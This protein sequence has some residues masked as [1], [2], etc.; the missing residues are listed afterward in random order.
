LGGTA[1]L[2]MRSLGGA[3]GLP[4]VARDAALVATLA[5]GN[6]TVQ[7]KGVNTPQVSLGGSLRAA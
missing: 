1:A 5:P 4:N 6:Y 7:V 2:T 3:F